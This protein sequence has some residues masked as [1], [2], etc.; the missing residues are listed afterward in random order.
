MA[1][2]AAVA[3]FPDDC[4]P[5]EGIFETR[6]AL[7]E[8]INAYAKPRGYAFI[9]QRSIREKTGR[10]TI[11]Y[12]YDRSRRLPSSPERARQR[13]TTTRITNCLFS[14][15]AKESSEGWALKHRQ[16]RRFTTHNHEPSL[17]PTAH[18]IYWKL[19][20]TPELKTLSNAGLAPKDI[21]TVVRQSGSLATRQDIYNRIAE[22]RRDSR[23]G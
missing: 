20:G 14:V 2:T 23:Q 22:V 1:S 16:D 5:P 3:S 12:A 18:P 7:F 21:Q 19:S 11:F 4:L 8:S 17:H 13:K 6:E 9:T 15:L 10:L